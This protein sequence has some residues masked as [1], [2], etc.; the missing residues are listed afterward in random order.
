MT[1]EYSG[2]Y[3]PGGET[4]D[5]D[6]DDVIS[7][8]DIG[9]MM[10]MLSNQTISDLGMPS[11]PSGFTLVDAPSGTVK[12]GDTCRVKVAVDNIKGWRTGGIGIVFSIDPSSTG[13]ATILGGEGEDLSGNRYDVSSAFNVGVGGISS[14]ALKIE[15]AGTII[16][17]ANTPQCG[18]GPGRYADAISVPGITSIVA[19]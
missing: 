4:H 13:T 15:S 11:R 16:I 14:I 3:P 18:T 6:S 9:I 7:S 19:E 8:G 2:V 1:T 5:L 12:V 17:N 10:I